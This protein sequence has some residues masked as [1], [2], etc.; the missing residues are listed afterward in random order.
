MLHIL[1]QQPGKSIEFKTSTH[2]VNYLTIQSNFIQLVG[3]LF[4]FGSFRECRQNVLLL[5]RTNSDF[6]VSQRMWTGADRKQQAWDRTNHFYKSRFINNCVHKVL[7]A[8][9]S[10][11]NCKMSE[12]EGILLH[13]HLIKSGTSSAMQRHTSQKDTQNFGFWF[14][15]LRHR[16]IFVEINTLSI[17]VSFIQLLSKPQWEGAWYTCVVAQGT[18]LLGLDKGSRFI[19][20]LK[21]WLFW[22]SL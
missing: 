18:E 9:C 5:R 2:N 16:I 20:V 11:R 8:H 7:D 12:L 13:S 14:W 17:S 21:L 22:K 15:F 6:S 4:Q 10:S 19:L 1:E 3:S